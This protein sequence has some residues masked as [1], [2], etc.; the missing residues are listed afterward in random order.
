VE[1][2]AALL[3]LS[4]CAF[5]SLAGLR[6]WSSDALL[7]LTTPVWVGYQ[8]TLFRGPGWYLYVAGTALSVAGSGLLVVGRVL[9][10]W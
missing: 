6:Y 8:R 2:L 10:R 9:L 5:M 1:F 4:G 7:F 3:I